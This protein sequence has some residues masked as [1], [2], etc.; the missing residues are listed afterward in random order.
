MIRKIKFES[1]DFEKYNHCIAQSCQRKFYA[2]RSFLDISTGKNWEILVCG[3]Y[4]AVM[5]IPLIRKL[6]VKVVINPKLCQQL[7]IFSINCLHAFFALEYH[8]LLLALML[9][10]CINKLLFFLTSCVPP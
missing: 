8:H 3:D 4:E 5:Q 2:E 7:G 6:G 1:I 9:I 10:F